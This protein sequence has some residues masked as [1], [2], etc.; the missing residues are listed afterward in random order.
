VSPSPLALAI[1]EDVTHVLAT[2]QAADEQVTVKRGEKTTALKPVIQA[3]R[4]LS[5][6]RFVDV[7]IVYGY[8][9]REALW[10]TT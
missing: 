9:A 7:G 1:R 8:V 3:L 10:T 5:H 6:R 4:Q 2:P